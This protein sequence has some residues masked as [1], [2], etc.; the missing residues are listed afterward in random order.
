MTITTQLAQQLQSLDQTGGLVELYV[1]DLTQI[2][3]SLYRFS[4]NAK[5]N[6][7]GLIWQGHL[8]T[9]MPIM[10][11]GWD[12]SGS[13]SL[14]RPTLS[15]S[16]VGHILINSI[17]TL[18]DLVGGSLTRYRTLEQFLDGGPSADPNAFL[19]PD[20]FMIEQLLEQTNVSITWQLSSILDRFGMQLPR[21]QVLK[22]KGFPGVGRYR[23]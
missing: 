19:P 20:V 14:P 2:G 1:L 12:L 18:G 15:I 23:Q 21:R 6:G 9:P 8:Y 13:G 16:N 10:T 5:A 11:Q 4:P 17:A 22:D 7:T 3:G